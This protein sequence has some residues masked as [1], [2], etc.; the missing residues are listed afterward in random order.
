MK[1]K[2]LTNKEIRELN[3]KI[4]RWNLKFN[5][6]D[7]LYFSSVDD[8]KVVIFKN[9]VQFFYY[10]NILVPSLHAVI[11]HKNTIFLMKPVVVDMG[12]VRF[13]VKGA[14]IMRPG[15]VE[16]SD[17]SKGDVVLIIDIDNRLPLALGVALYDSEDVELMKKGKVIKNI[18]CV[19]DKIWNFRLR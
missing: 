7:E 19:G 2:R 9:Q 1:L 12:A 6:N 3:V 14:D 17:F 13:V 15:V 10:N 8:I 4:S 16:L 18:H 5:K 11:E